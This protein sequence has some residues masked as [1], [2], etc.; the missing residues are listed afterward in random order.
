MKGNELRKIAESAG[1]TPIEVLH[2]AG[3]DSPETLRKVY[4]DIRVRQTTRSKIE[5]AIKRL[6]A[7]A[8]A[9]AV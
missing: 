9:V 6:A 1:L 4:N 3:I 2:E 5:N 8:K 7:K